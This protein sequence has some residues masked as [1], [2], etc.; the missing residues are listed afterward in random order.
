MTLM[1]WN[2]EDDRMPVFSNFWNPFSDM[3]LNTFF[4][5]TPT[6]RNPSVNIIEGKDDFRIEVAAA[7][8][9][10]KDFRIDLDNN[11]LIIEARKEMKKDEKDERYTRRDFCYNSFQR[12]FTL[13]DTIDGE[14]IDANYSDGILK[15]TLPKREEAKVKPAREINIS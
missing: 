2:R 4:G 11:L 7:G 15:I 3:E 9:E 8:M 13:P 12:T 14:K 10:K 1:K 6:Y 5:N